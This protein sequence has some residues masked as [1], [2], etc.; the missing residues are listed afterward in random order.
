MNT[1]CVQLRLEPEILAQEPKGLPPPEAKSF[2]NGC[3]KRAYMTES[4]QRE[5]GMGLCCAGT[6]SP[7]CER[8]EV[9]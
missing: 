5:G 6:G 2:P 1:S 8:L 3:F 9:E 7:V 4:S